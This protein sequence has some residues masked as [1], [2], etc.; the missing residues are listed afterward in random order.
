MM[1]RKFILGL[2][3]LGA[4][5]IGILWYLRYGHL[6]G[7]QMTAKDARAL[8]VDVKGISAQKAAMHGKVQDFVRQEQKRAQTW[9]PAGADEPRIDKILETPKTLEEVMALGELLESSDEFEAMQALQALIKVRDPKLLPGLMAIFKRYTEDLGDY[10]D[11]LKSLGSRDFARRYSVARYLAVPIGEMK[12]ESALPELWHVLGKLDG[13]ESW[14]LSRYG[15]KLLPQLVEH[16]QAE[17]DKWAKAAACKAISNIEDLAAKDELLDVFKRNTQSDIREA[18]ACALAGMKD[19]TV[20]NELLRYFKKEPERLVRA[21]IISTLKDK[22]DLPFIIAVLN[23]RDENSMV[24]TT[25]VVQMGKI[26]DP[27]S[28]PVLEEALK[29][30]DREVRYRS[31]RAL[32][33]I[34]GREYEYE[35]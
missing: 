27:S 31:Y 25:A 18:A 11:I 16:A 22:K 10:K 26:G 14:A 32:L 29:D 33:K 6:P 19:E 8:N 20:S 3:V 1:R 28:V 17:N 23:D 13:A 12:D 21:S 7:V 15:A 30:K 35:K 4:L 2:I 24:R 9:K 34:T 5:I